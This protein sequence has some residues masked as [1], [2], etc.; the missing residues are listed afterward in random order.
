MFCVIGVALVSSPQTAGAQTEL[1]TTF[2]NDT[3]RRVNDLHIKYTHDVSITQDPKTFKKVSGTNL[4]KLTDGVV[5]VDESIEIVA[6]RASGDIDINE[7]WWTLDGEQQGDVH[8]GCAAPL[9]SRSGETSAA[10]M[11]TDTLEGIVTV[12]MKS[13]KGPVKLRLPAD[14]RAGDTISGTVVDERKDARDDVSAVEINGQLHKLS[15]KILTFVVPKAGLVYPFIFK[16]SAGR[17][18]G[19]GVIPKG[20]TGNIPSSV[21]FPP[22]G[23]DVVG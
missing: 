16:N 3:G 11:A 15:N 17:E 19:R 20:F 13:D 18:V 21:S 23:S 2:K 22:A 12:E 4:K 6:K 9:C 8:K 1:T 10:S 7:W 14:M 5:D